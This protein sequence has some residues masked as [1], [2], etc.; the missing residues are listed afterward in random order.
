MTAS[1]VDAVRV[2]P[3]ASVQSLIVHSF[4]SALLLMLDSTENAVAPWGRPTR[5][6]K[7]EI[8]N[9]IPPIRNIVPL[10]WHSCLQKSRNT[11]RSQ[12]KGARASALNV[13]GENKVAAS[14]LRRAMWRK[15]NARLALTVNPRV[16]AFHLLNLLRGVVLADIEPG[17]KISGLQ[18]Q[19]T[20]LA[21]PV[22]PQQLE[23]LKS[24]FQLNPPC[25]RDSNLV[26]DARPP[27]SASTILGKVHVPPGTTKPP[28][29]YARL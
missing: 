2:A 21:F 27:S 16:G 6:Q 23:K 17:N 3:F 15:W 5:F 28:R 10:T 18:L 29:R 11:I 19:K 14:R 22:P 7:R 13:T 24:R 8:R 9:Q 4:A 12:R 25:N 26:Y 1:A 20:F